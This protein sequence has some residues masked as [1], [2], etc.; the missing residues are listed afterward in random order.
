MSREATLAII[1]ERRAISQAIVTTER[2][3][4]VAHRDHGPTEEWEAANVDKWNAFEAAID[5]I[6]G[7][8]PWTSETDIV[9][10]AKYVVKATD[11]ALA[12]KWRLAW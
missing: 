1:A 2:V 9:S 8:D 5:V 6:P 11:Y 7:I 4:Y 3:E 10:I 12:R